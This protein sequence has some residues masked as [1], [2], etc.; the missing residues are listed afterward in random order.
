MWELNALNLVEPAAWGD[1]R[2]ISFFN[3]LPRIPMKMIN[4]IVDGDSL[5]WLSVIRSVSPVGLGDEAH[6]RAEPLALLDCGEGGDA[7]ESPACCIGIS[8][9]STPTRGRDFVEKYAAK[10]RWRVHERTRAL[11]LFDRA[12]WRNARNISVSIVLPLSNI[13]AA[14]LFLKD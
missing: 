13:S 3:Y 12:V 14:R 5:Y 8:D 2:M 11:R 4:E 1:S 9:S 7:S 6:D 10:P